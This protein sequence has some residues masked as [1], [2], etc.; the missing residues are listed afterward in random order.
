[1]MTQPRPNGYKY[2]IEQILSRWEHDDPIR[3]PE[4][5]FRRMQV[6][7]QLDIPLA[8]YT[9]MDPA[10][11]SRATDLYKRLEAANLQLFQ[12]IRNDIQQG[13][14][15][16]IFLDQNRKRKVP[17]GTGY[18]HLDD[19][20]SGVLQLDEPEPEQ[21]LTSSE[22]VFYQPTPARHIFSLIRSAKITST[23]L[24]ID[25]GSGLGHVPLLVSACT[26]ART[27]GIELEPAYVA[28]ARKSAAD[29]NLAAASFI[30][31]DARTTDLS[32]GT[33]FY[34]YTPFTGSIL[35]SVLDSLREQASQCPIKIATFGPCCATIAQEPWLAPLM[36]PEPNRVTIFRSH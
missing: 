30:A 9:T 22:S 23:D 35:H 5:F 6:L 33:V 8:F 2:L 34:L 17:T 24:V 20:V 13:T 7:D 19:L 31:E 26:G 15:P 4:N 32:T 14:R 12:T 29:L 16:S 36:H 27:I 18:D 3:V 28:C 10:L 11:H 1:M 25:L 21:A